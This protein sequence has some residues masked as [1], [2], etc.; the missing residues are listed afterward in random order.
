MLFQIFSS[1]NSRIN[2]NFSNADPFSTVF[3]PILFFC[4]IFTRSYR[5]FL[6]LKWFSYF[7]T[8]VCS[9]LTQFTFILPIFRH[10]QAIYTWKKKSS[11]ND[12]F[13]SKI[14]I[15]IEIGQQIH[16]F[17]FLLRFLK[18][19]CHEIRFLIEKLKMRIL[20]VFPMISWIFYAFNSIDERKLLIFWLQNWISYIFS[21]LNKN[22][23]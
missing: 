6:I 19:K 8:Y 7:N 17:Y 18:W 20:R 1:N 21:V 23:I 10:S 13:T 9:F 16:W 22:V 15:L 14:C 5:N 4:H 3:I 12:I 2:N 11:G